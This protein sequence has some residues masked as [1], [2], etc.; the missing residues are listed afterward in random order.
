MSLVLIHVRT[1][2][3]SFGLR[4]LGKFNKNPATRNFNLL[5]IFLRNCLQIPTN[6]MYII[7]LF[8][9]IK[10]P[11]F[12]RNPSINFLPT[13]VYAEKNIFY[14]HNVRKIPFEITSLIFS[15]TSLYSS[16]KQFVQIKSL[17]R[18]WEL[19]ISHLGNMRNEYPIQ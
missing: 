18:N 1:I 3:H 19:H 12:F 8:K 15:V 6:Y 9:E 2:F 4:P 10:L 17:D 14:Y 13:S 16:I 5:K 7:D 11:S